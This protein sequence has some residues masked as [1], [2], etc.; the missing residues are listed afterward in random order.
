MN[1]APAS[2]A[3]NET[4]PAT[5]SGSISRLIACGARMTSSSASSSEI[6]WAFAWSGIWPS[7]SG[8]RT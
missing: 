7:T 3:R 8:V 1:D 5:S 6:P 2:L 4:T